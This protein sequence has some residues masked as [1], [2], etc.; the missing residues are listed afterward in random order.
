MYFQKGLSL[1][2]Y[3]GVFLSH[4][5]DLGKSSHSIR[6]AS[7]LIE[8]CVQEM[9]VTS[10]KTQRRCLPRPSSS[11]NSQ[12]RQDLRRWRGRA[13]ILNIVV[14]D[15]WSIFGHE[16]CRVY[17]AL[18]ASGSYL[19]K[20]AEF[21]KTTWTTTGKEIARGFI[22]PLQDCIEYHHGQASTS[23]FDPLAIAS[24]MTGTEHSYRRPVLLGTVG[25]K[26]S[27]FYKSSDSRKKGGHQI[28][29]ISP[30]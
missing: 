7:G 21:A 2:V 18:V 26:I 23:F 25:N 16:S 22:K 17:E 3:S 29:A 20:P 10:S 6:A 11:Q 27:P 14:N 19:T 8:G 9:L 1:E 12:F 28:S 4:A 15:L 24:H 30:E 13:S 5:K